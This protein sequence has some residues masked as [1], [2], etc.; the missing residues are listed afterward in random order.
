MRFIKSI[1]LVIF[2]VILSAMPAIGSEGGSEMDNLL[3]SV[4]IPGNANSIE[5]AAFES[6]LTDEAGSD[7]LSLPE[8]LEFAFTENPRIIAA[9]ANWQAMVEMYPQATSLPDPKLNVNWSPQPIETREGSFDYAFQIMQMIPN[10]HRLNLMGDLALTRAEMAKVGYEKKVRDVLT[11][12]MKSY[13]ELGYLHQAIGIA[14]VNRQYFE[15]LVEF[16]NLRYS[17]DAIGNAELYTAESRLGQAEYEEI[18]LTELLYTEESNLRNLLGVDPDFPIGTI[19]LPHSEPVEL[20]L[21]ILRERV[22]EYRHELEMA[23]VSVEIAEVNVSIARSMDDPNFS[24]GFMYN[25]IGTSPMSDGM[26]TSGNDAW[27]IMFGITIPIWDGKNDARV[28]QAQAQLENA[29]ANLEDQGNQAYADI[30]RIYWQLQNQRRLVELY[31]VTLL[32]EAMTAVE[33]SQTWYEDGQIPFTNLVETT[34]I[35]Q[36]FQL[37]TVRAE[38]DYLKSLAELQKLTGIPVFESDEEVE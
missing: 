27:G 31:R 32:P 33:L 14:Q 8:L 5:P 11:D 9:R 3:A 18:L 2:L 17:Q 37:A 6:G 30:E 1:T 36:N 26:R 16:G 19:S 20:D 23:G 35:M 12:V 15:Q 7:S 13:F 38:T 10:P 34:M 22:T 21:E 4:E 29:I 25:L 24:L 28:D